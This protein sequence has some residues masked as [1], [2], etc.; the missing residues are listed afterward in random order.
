MQRVTVTL[1]D[2]LAAE[3]DRFMAARGYD[4]RSE[5]LR[6]LTRAGMREAVVASGEAGRALGVLIYVYDHAVRDLARRVAGMHHDQADLS[7]ATLHVHLDR[8]RCLEI[9]VLSGEAGDLRHLASDVIAERGVRHGQLVVVPE[10]VPE[11]ARR[12]AGPGGSE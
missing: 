4:N 9:A 6:D 1:D 2:D 3:L 8:D 11:R 5:A 7:V 12:T 10:A